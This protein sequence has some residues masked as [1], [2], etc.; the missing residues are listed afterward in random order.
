MRVTS[1]CAVAGASDGVLSFAT[2]WRQAVTQNIV[3][4]NNIA[5]MLFL[6]LV[7][8]YLFSKHDCALQ[9]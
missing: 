2:R 6:I 1:F 5:T 3:A 7:Q 8:Y 9:I 4:R